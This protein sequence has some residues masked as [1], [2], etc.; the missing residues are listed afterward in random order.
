MKALVLIGGKG[1]RL[2][3][4]TYTTTKAMLQIANIP[5]VDRLIRRLESHGVTEIIFAINYLAE[6]MKAYLENQRNRFRARVICSLEPEPLGSA[7][8]V[9]FNERH[10]NE[11][12]LLLNGDI[13]TD[14]DYADLVRFHREKKALVT[15]NVTEIPDPTRFGVIDMNSE[16]RVICWQEKPSLE[17][18]RS[19]WTNVGVWAMEPEILLEI[20]VGQFV[21]LER[22]VFQDLVR[23]QAPFYGYKAYGYWADIGTPESYLALHRDVLSGRFLATI[24]GQEVQENVWIASNCDISLSTRLQKP[25]VIGE[26]TC[27]GDDVSIFGP[28]AIGSNCNIERSVSIRD[29]VIWDDTVVGT[30]TSL[31]GSIVGRNVQIAS[32]VSIFDSVIGDDSVIDIPMV[33]SSRLGPGTVLSQDSISTGR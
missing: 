16:G 9:K 17:E 14:L 27:I 19:N 13:L 24:P 1:T 11:T 29:T 22:Q 5:F 12:F 31:N 21:S 26:A 33:R 3:P 28:I 18:A 10:L 2:R 32:N 7:G 30:G 23:T 20:P 4:L 15:V 8:A 25:V 6:E